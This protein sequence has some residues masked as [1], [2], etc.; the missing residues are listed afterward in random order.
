MLVAPKADPVIGLSFFAVIFVVCFIFALFDYDKKMKKKAEEEKRQA[1]KEQTDLCVS[2]LRKNLKKM[3]KMGN[4]P[5]CTSLEQSQ[6]LVDLGINTKTADMSYVLSHNLAPRLTLLIDTPNGLLRTIPAWSLSALINLLSEFLK[7][8]S[9]DYI[10]TML[11]NRVVYWQ[12]EM[13]NL[14]ESTEGCLLD[15][16]VETIEWLVKEGRL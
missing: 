1:E 9:T 14:Y 10:L 8:N 3:L 2:I 5:L 6:R 15:S 16:E 4:N 12:P 11:T 7:E 13:D